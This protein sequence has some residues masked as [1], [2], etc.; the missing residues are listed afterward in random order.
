M[1]KRQSDFLEN[2]HILDDTQHGFRPVWSILSAA[3]NFIG[4]IEKGEV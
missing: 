2:N 1:Y 4:S 3:V